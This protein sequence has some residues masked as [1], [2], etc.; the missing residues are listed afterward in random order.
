MHYLSVRTFQLGKCSIVYI[1]RVLF[2]VPPDWPWL[3]LA[4]YLKIVIALLHRLP[5]EIDF[6]LNLHKTKPFVTAYSFY[7]L[8]Y[9]CSRLVQRS[10]TRFRGCKQNTKSLDLVYVDVPGMQHLLNIAPDKE[11]RSLIWTTYR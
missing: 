7:F 6:V 5:N 3:Y 1:S 4:S 11:T 10:K 8:S 9:Y 2:A